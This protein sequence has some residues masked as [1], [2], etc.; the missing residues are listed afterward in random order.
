[1]D[2]F[3]ATAKT[4][5]RVI[6]QMTYNIKCMLVGDS[7]V[8]KS[9]ILLNFTDGRFMPGGCQTIGVDYGMRSMTIHDQKVRMQIWDTSG[10][11]RFR[12]IIH[13]HLTKVTVVVV[14]YDITDR[15]SFDT[16]QQYWLPYIYDQN[17]PTDQRVVI[18]GNK[19]D[20]DSD[21]QVSTDEGHALASLWG[22]PFYEVSAATINDNIDN[23]FHLPA[24]DVMRRIIKRLIPP[25][26]MESLGISKDEPW[27]FVPEPLRIETR[28]KCCWFF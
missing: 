19:A 15:R 1:M 24:Q 2:V 22:L 9:S 8:G 12:P 16:V 4:L 14:V 23:V 21:R 17:F 26:D 5:D 27:H 25:R 18:V 10:N 13:A 6:K 20:R 11:E 28:T 7:G 3:K